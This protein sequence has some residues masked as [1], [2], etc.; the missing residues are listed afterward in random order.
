MKSEGCETV[1]IQTKGGACIQVRVR[2]YRRT[3]DRQNGKRYKGVYAGL[4]LFGIHDR[5]T[6]GLTSMV[7]AWSAL[8]SSFEEVRQ[9]LCDHGIMLDVKVI[10]KLAYRYAE[11]ARAVQQAGRMPLDEKENLQGRR[12]VIS[13]D[14]GRTRLREKK[15]G[16]RTAKGRTRYHG[17][18]REPKLLIIYVVDAHGKQE[19]SFNPFIDGGFNGPDGLF[20]LL[21]GY[22]ES[23]SIQQ[24]DKVLFVAD[25]AHWI[26][27]RVPG[28]IRSLDLNPDH[29]YELLDFYHA[30]EHLG[31]VV[32]LR[33]SWSAKERKSWIAK[34]RRL[35]LK[36]ESAAVVQAVQTLCRGRNSKAIRTERDYFV[37]NEQRLAF[38]TVKA[39]N[40]PIGSGAIESS[41][42]RVVNLRLKGP[43][44]F[45]YKENAEKMIMLRSYY[46]AGR[47]NCL[48]QMANSHFSLLA[49]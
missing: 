38:P 22:L 11:R 2:Y 14:G 13:T 23:L 10:R 33:K 37:R 46:K 3:C 18:W 47:W 44:I 24:A 49:A 43:C 21:K 19:K 12:V 25:G 45:W 36:G 16:P 26:W 41:I 31:K 42:R 32:G 7:S 35:L 20:Q 5:C 6:P 28:L 15:R 39:L 27:N 17:S 8:L 9:V 29:V 4:V 30:V 40:L 1:R 34:Q 48:K